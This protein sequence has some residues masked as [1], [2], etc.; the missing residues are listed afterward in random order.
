M[1]LRSVLLGIL[2][3]AVFTATATT[4]PPV[5][6]Q[7]LLIENADTYR[8]FG[9]APKYRSYLPAS[10]DLSDHFPE[11][12]HQGT[13]GSCTAWAVGYGVRSYYE[14]RDLPAERV[15][16]DLGFSPAYLYNQVK[17]KSGDCSS[18]AYISHA[19]KL[20]KTDGIAPLP[21][22]PYT[23]ASC[24]ALPDAD[25]KMRAANFIIDDWYRISTRDIDDIKGTLAKGDPVIIGMMIPE[26]FEDLGKNTIY[27]GPNGKEEEFAHAM[28]VAGYNDRSST[29]RIFNSWGKDWADDGYAQ[30]SYK[31][32]TDKV[33]VAYAMKVSN[34]GKL[35]Q[36]YAKPKLP[37][38]IMP[39]A[40]PPKNVPTL[41]DIISGAN[42]GKACANL[43]LDRTGKASR[44]S[45][46]MGSQKTLE[47]LR[48]RI[49]KQD[50]GIAVDYDVAVRPWP[51]CE[52]L[53][54][55][56]D[57]VAAPQGLAITI[58]DRAGTTVLK[59]GDFLTVH[60]RTP[61]FPSYIYVTYLQSGG[62]A[63]HLIQPGPNDAPIAPGTDLEFGRDPLKNRFRISPPFGDEMIVAVASARPLFDTAAP[64]VQIEREYLSAF[65]QAF[66]GQFKGK[67]KSRFAGAVTYLSTLHQ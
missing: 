11:P 10:V 21:D 4:L 27:D 51:Q 65:R 61:S 36:L 52:T 14:F 60:V 5:R 25:T 66:L 45:G 39:V 8:S 40:E 48:A 67:T 34:R 1:A 19:L 20:L 23:S 57:A 29:F 49:A 28:V 50:T 30:V 13:Q 43:V 53:Q 35:V 12:G 56:N 24:S 17:L 62:E 22:F 32:F 2:G 63:V 18:G 41:E 59:Q 47:A 54:T 33:V 38:V 3:I 31:A 37:A 64:I 15:P 58:S 7:G 42:N 44:I 26:S 46:F 55:F 6:A 16:R 9:S